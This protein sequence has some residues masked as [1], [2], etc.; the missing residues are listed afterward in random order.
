M[1]IKTERLLIRNFEL[2]DAQN[3]FELDTDPDVMRFMGGP[4]QISI[5][6][7]IATLER[8]FIYYGKHPGLGIFECELNDANEFIGWGALKHLDNRIK[9]K[10]VTDS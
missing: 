3:I 4:M 2:T 1:K 9:L 5:D 6:D 10:S 8:Q 7:S